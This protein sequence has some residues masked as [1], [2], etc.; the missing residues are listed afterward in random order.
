MEFVQQL[1]D[2]SIH[3][4]VNLRIRQLEISTTTRGFRN[5]KQESESL[6]RRESA[7]SKKFRAPRFSRIPQLKTDSPFKPRIW[8]SPDI[9]TK[10][11]AHS[12]S[13]LSSRACSP[14][15]RQ[16]SKQYF[17]STNHVHLLVRIPG[18]PLGLPSSGTR[19]DA[20]HSGG[21]LLPL[22]PLLLLEGRRISVNTRP[23]IRPNLELGHL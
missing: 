3:V 13:V 21:D 9:K 14:G 4:F 15:R 19:C 20:Q 22:F 7:E 17:P 5:Q 2:L 23:G 11:L 8:R 6:S 16:A 12:L 1:N 10:S 18:S